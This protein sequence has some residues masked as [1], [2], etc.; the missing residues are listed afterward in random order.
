MPAIKTTTGRYGKSTLQSNNLTENALKAPLIYSKMIQLYPQYSLTYLTEG[1]GRVKAFD[2][3]NETWG[4]DRY[5]WFMRG[6][7]NKPTTVVGIL[8]G[9]GTSEVEVRVNENYVNP[10]DVVK[11]KTGKLCIVVGEVMGSG[12]F[13]VKLQAING[14]ANTGTRDVLSAADIPAGSALNLISNLHYEKSK[15]GYGNIG[16]PD[17]YINYLS[18]HRRGMTVS[19]DALGDVTWI[20]SPKGGKLWYFTAEAEVEEQMYKTIDNWRWYGRNTMK[21]DGTPLFTLDGKPMI[22]GDGMLAQ[23][24]GINDYTFSSSNEVNENRLTEY[25]QYLTTKCQDFKNN[26]WIVFG[27]MKAELMFH[28]SMKSLLYE[29]GNVITPY[30]DLA[31]GKEITLGGNFVGYRVGTNLVTFTRVSTFDDETLHQERDEDGDLLESSRMVFM[32]VGKIENE[33]NI[34]I[35]VKA[36]PFGN[37]AMIKKYIPGI[38]SPFDMNPSSISPNSGDGF[39]V[40]W[41]NHSGIIIKNPYGCGQWIKTKQY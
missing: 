23:I 36:S 12:P 2:L 20:E 33:S 14:N 13:V 16:F 5:E 28:Q 19:G 15:Q 18:K 41:F 6:R 38:V 8:S 22:A 10:F 32:N 7:K 34:T 31:S 27:G 29:K 39:D 35:A 11:T 4:S 30:G 3:K 24:E 25:I 1:T 17:K 40:E 21:V 37:R 9:A 26:H